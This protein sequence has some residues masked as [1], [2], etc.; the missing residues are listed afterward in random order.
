MRTKSFIVLVFT[1]FGSV[2]L[3]GQESRKEICIDFRVGKSTLDTA[4]VNNAERLAEIVSFLETVKNDEA[5]DLVEVSFCGSASPEGSAG[6]NRRLAEERRAAVENYVLRRISLPDSIITRCDATIAWERLASLVEQ[7]DMPHKG[8]AVDVLRN[9]PE[10]TYD[11]KGILI[12]SKKKHLMEL[13]YGRTW[14]YMLER[15]FPQVRN[16]GVIFVTVR[17]KPIIK[18]DKVE[19]QAGPTMD[20]VAVVQKTD[21]LISQVIVPEHEERKPFYMAVKTNMLYDVLAVPNIDKNSKHRYWRIY[22]GDIAVRKWLGRKAA[23]KPLTGHHLGLYGQV[24][25]YDFEWGGTGY[26]GGRPGKTLWNSP[27]YAMGVEYGYSL[28]IARRLNID[29]TIGVGYW[30]GKYYTYSPLDGHD[31]WE[32][33]KKRHWFGPTKAEISL[34]WLLG[35]GNSN[36]RKGGMK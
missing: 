14:Y 3:F 15:F 10:Y 7:S 22:G 21:T 12:D 29:F 18:N 5:L 28:P 20:T 24:F 23:E 26:M 32:S 33:T 19:L 27:N 2:H 31:V 13:Q 30:G 17:Q 25:T 35:R 8:E 9:D 34:V 1:L 36:N 4:Y 16:A 11:D 6:I